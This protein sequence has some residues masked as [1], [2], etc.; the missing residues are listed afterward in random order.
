MIQHPDFL[1]TDWDAEAHEHCR[2]GAR[3]LPML[4]PWPGKLCAACGHIDHQCPC[5]DRCCESCGW[6]P[7]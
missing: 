5:R 3:L 7:S 4:A 1:T 2:C 6:G